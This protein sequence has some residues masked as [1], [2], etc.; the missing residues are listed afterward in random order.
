MVEKQQK[1]IFCTAQT[2]QEITV[3]GRGSVTK[4]LAWLLPKA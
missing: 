2:T 4:S 1:A 3:W